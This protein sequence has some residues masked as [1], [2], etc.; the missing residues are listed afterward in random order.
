[1]KTFIA[2]A[3]FVAASAF[4]ANSPPPIDEAVVAALVKAGMSEAQVRAGYNACDSGG[5]ISMKI[6]FR[7]RL[8]GETMTLKSAYEDLH[9][10][11]RLHSE[12]IAKELEQGQAA[13]EK[14]Q[15]LHCSL[16]GNISTFDYGTEMLA[17]Q[18]QLTQLRT[19]ALKEMSQR[20]NAVDR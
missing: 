7:Y 8:E 3:L 15:Y 4:A 2:V 19:K 5:P 9:N 18:W 13:W 6:C 12:S 20:W 17:C 16:E 1:M 14:Y 10:S 11:L